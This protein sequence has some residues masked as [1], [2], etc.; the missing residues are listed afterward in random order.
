MIAYVVAF[1]IWLPLGPPGY[2]SFE[3]LYLNGEAKNISANVRENLNIKK[4]KKNK[5]ITKRVR[6]K[7]IIPA[8]RTKK[9]NF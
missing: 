5:S 7:I 2:A 9:K 1:L 8:K 3:S 4:I 6:V